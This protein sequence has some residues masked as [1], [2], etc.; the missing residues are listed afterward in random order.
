M[1]SR[2]GSHWI[3]GEDRRRADFSKSSTVNF[4]D[5]F[6]QSRNANADCKG[7]L[8]FGMTVITE[9]TLYSLLL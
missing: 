1:D 4:H 7:K 3:T 5:I 8:G 6:D 2:R 9:M